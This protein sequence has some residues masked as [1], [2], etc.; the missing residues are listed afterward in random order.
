MDL[1]I[2]GQVLQT[3]SAWRGMGRYSRNLLEALVRARPRWRMAVVQNEL[4]QP[5]DPAWLAGLPVLRLRPPLADHPQHS[6]QSAGNELHY[7]DWLRSWAADL[8]L[9]LSPFDASAVTPRFVG[10]RPR[11]AGILYDLIP[12]LYPEQYLNYPEAQNWYARRFRKLLHYD[13]L[14]SISEASTRDLARHAGPGGPLPRVTTVLGATDPSFAPYPESDLGRRRE[15]LR[16]RFGLRRDFILFVGGGDFRKNM[17]GSLRAFAA[18]PEGARRDVDLVL[19]CDL[20]EQTRARLLAEAEALGVAGSVRLTGFVADEELL[21][22]YQLCR[23]FF[24]PSLYEGLGLPVLEALHCGAPVVAANNSSLPE[25]AGD[26]CWLADPADPSALA[27]ALAAALAE[28]RDL[29]R[30]QRVAHARSFRWEDVAERAARALEELPA[31]RVPAAPAP[32]ARPRLAWVSPLPPA[33]SGIADYCGDLLGHLAPHYDVELVVDGRQP[34]VAPEL[35]RRHLI[36]TGDEAPSRHEARP[37][38]LF[39]YHL[40]NSDFHV[41]QVPLLHQYPGL[42]VLHDFHLGGLVHS[43]INAGRWAATA[44]DELEHEGEGQFATWVR[45]G[46]VAPWAGRFLAPH[47]RR[48]LELAEAVVVHS[49][50]A[51]QRVRRATDAPAVMVPMAVPLPELEGPAELRRRLGLPA[52]AFV[53]CTLGVVGPPKRVASLFRAVAALPPAIRDRTLVA[54]VGPCPPEARRPLADL[55]ERL[56]LDESV[57]WTDHVPLEDFSAYARAADVCVQLR[58]PSNGETSAALLR[59]MAAGAACVASDQGPMLELPSQAVWKVRSPHHEV[60]DLTAALTRLHDHP[61]QRAGLAAAARRYAAEH[62]NPGRAAA[63][64]VAVIDQLLQRRRGR[65]HHWEE[66][67]CNAMAQSFLRP[68]QCAAAVLPSWA[69]LHCQAPALPPF[70]PAAARGQ[71]AAA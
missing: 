51:Y 60:E 50:W 16:A 41:Y 12:L 46:A 56:G 70:A 61:R 42:V 38:D 53:V 26:V 22:L 9:V 2:D 30:A 24:F 10:R 11:L 29:R 7:G 54:V 35:T 28:P 64:Y 37:Y 32:P 59:A 71:Q 55:A 47:N 39:V 62:L 31:A 44:A 66:A 48:L 5:A 63:L 3:D 52:D 14:L 36:V 34:Q 18:V 43:A 8:V 57:R 6:R 58:Y 27:A 23:V 65:D 17:S 33:P 20:E 49:A 40:G 19:A 15:R 69:A 21:A 25:Y 67:A 13:A 4:L 45:M 68:E 1:L